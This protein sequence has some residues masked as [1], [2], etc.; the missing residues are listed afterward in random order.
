MKWKILNDMKILRFCC[1][2]E[3][4]VA[5][6][7]DLWNRPL[8]L[9]LVR[10]CVSE[11]LLQCVRTVSDSIETTVESAQG[12]VESGQKQLLLAS[13]YQ[14]PLVNICMMCACWLYRIHVTC[15]SLTESFVPNSVFYLLVAQLYFDY[16]NIFTF[17]F[18]F[19]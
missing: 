4:R 6:Y 13:S 10:L 17:F 9:S 16:F 2:F 1:D 14:V 18:C 3:K 7:N 19:S 8:S 12:H 15:V 11:K 5:Y